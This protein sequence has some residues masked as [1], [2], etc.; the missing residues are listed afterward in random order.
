M[1]DAVTA[2]EGFGAQVTS[3]TDGVL[4]VTA[5]DPDPGN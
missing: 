2:L 5:H 3:E 4:Q 1:A